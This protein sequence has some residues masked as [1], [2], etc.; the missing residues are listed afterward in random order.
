VGLAVTDSIN[1]SVSWN[2][3]WKHE[4]AEAFYAPPLMPVHSASLTQSRDVGSQM[5]RPHRMALAEHVEF[6]TT[7]IWFEP[8]AVAG[9]A[10]G[11]SGSPFAA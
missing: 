4:A 3:L 8:R 11:R 2:A 7:Y 6:A 9:Q 10:G 5:G 1:V